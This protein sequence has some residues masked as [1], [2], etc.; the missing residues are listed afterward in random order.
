M[1]A[2][3]LKVR[4]GSLLQNHI[5]TPVHLSIHVMPIWHPH[6][7]VVGVAVKSHLRDFVPSSQCEESVCSGA[8]VHT[9]AHAHTCASH[10][11]THA[12]TCRCTY[13][14]YTSTT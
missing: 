12:Y 3:V 4:A 7:L 9:L 10:T 2:G 14:T 11:Y 8:G 5:G 1:R 13:T 6:V